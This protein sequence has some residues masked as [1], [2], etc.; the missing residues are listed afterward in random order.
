MFEKL[1]GV[2][3]RFVE[4]ER[5]MS[6]PAVLADRE[7]YQKYLREHA[8]ISD[9]VEGFR[10]YREVVQERHENESL[11]RD[12][13]PEIRE[14]AEE[15]SRR[16]ESL[17]KSLADTLRMLLIPKDPNDGKNIILEIRAGTGGDEA[18]LFA[19]DLFR[20]YA[21]YAE[22]A[23]WKIE[24]LDS[25]EPDVG[26]FKEV[27]AMVQGRGVYSVMKYESGIHRVQRVPATE[28][29][30]RIH[31]SAVTVAVLPEA[32][33][34][35]VHV[36]EKDLRIDTYRSQGAG[37]QHVNTTDSAVRITHIP[38]GIVV[39]CQ[40]EKSQHKN[41]LKAMQVLRARMYDAMAQEQAAKRSADRKEQ[42]GTGDR[43]GRIRT[44]NYPQ[45]RVTDHRIGLTLYRLE[46]ILQ[47][48][49]AQLVDALRTHYQAEALQH[50]GA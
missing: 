10:H 43:S 28:T 11:L 33:E 24:I 34:V 49:M 38:T 1:A 46:S 30:G 42:V 8:E 40:D 25:N 37:G 12:R 36:D 20:M 5:L 45:G 17:E 3:D 6:D 9:L 2:E 13:D 16:L 15:E 22:S 50:G 35:D 47:G 29:Q 14:M 39:Q 32:E 19:G 21:R 27:V 26:G 18:A 48:D 4:L 7:R 31:T 44:Y 23:G 41:R